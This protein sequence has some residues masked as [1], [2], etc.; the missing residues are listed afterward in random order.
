MRK[1]EQGAVTI[2]CII[3]L[4]S[5]ILLGGVM[6][7]GSRIL[8]ARQIVRTSMNSA[9][10]STL[11]YYSTDLVGDFGLYGVTE[12]DAKTQFK[13]YF[14]NNLTLSQNDGFNLYQFELGSNPVSVKVSAPLSQTEVFA[15][16]MSE[17]SKYRAGI[18]LTIGVVKKVGMLFGDKGPGN[19]VFGAVD[20]SEKA[21]NDLKKQSDRFGRAVNT[22]LSSALDTQVKKVKEETMEK[23][24]NGAS[25]E[26]INFGGDILETLESVKENF[27]EMN[28]ALSAY[29]T[30]SQ[31]ANDKINSAKMTGGEYYDEE[32][33]TWRTASPNGNDN[34]NVSGNENTP[35]KQAQEIIDNA[36][37]TVAQASQGV[38]NNL[39]QIQAES[40]QIAVHQQ[41]INELN[42]KLGNSDQNAE[43]SLENTQKEMA[44][45]LQDN[46]ITDLTQ[47]NTR[48]EKLENQRSCL[49][50]GMID[51]LDPEIT[52]DPVLLEEEI[53][54]QKKLI[55]Q[56]TTLQNTLNQ[57]QSVADDRKKLKKELAEEEKKLDDVYKK[58]ENLYD[59]MP[60]S[61]T[62]S[63][64]INYEITV[65]DA[66]QQQSESDLAKA[67]QAVK[68]KLLGVM[69]EMGKNPYSVE[70][71]AGAVDVE[72]TMPK[73]D[74]DLIGKLKDT[75]SGIIEICTKPETLLERAY[76]VEYALD[77]FTFLTSQSSRPSHHFHFGE[78]E[79]FLKGKD[80][81]GEN[82][83]NVVSDITL[84]RLV[85][86]F[87]D[88]LI[89]TQSPEPLS[90]ALIALGRALMDTAG[91]IYEL[92]INGECV[93][94][95]SFKNVKLTYSDHLRLALLLQ[96]VGSKTETQ[97]R[98]LTMIDRTMDVKKAN[99]TNELYTRI[100]A[101]SEV[102]INLIMVTL[103][104]FGKMMPGQDVIQDGKF[105]IR[106][107][108][109][110]GY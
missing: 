109:S 56:G 58:I 102:K 35:G 33:K 16:Q 78:V 9:A 15:D 99:P 93:L 51:G 10:R 23:L 81:Q 55:E 92:L 3:V 63:S 100:E 21:Y 36:S 88:D 47:L 48:L 67:I 29:N 76:T 104:M 103:P 20:D 28:G 69:E 89:H 64:D 71:N 73:G 96:T 40:Q 30:E 41:K 86:N 14:E 34:V 66:D 49:E 17:Y 94:C 85:I 107:T 101:T 38:Q 105:T 75:A 84:L 97:Q 68:N 50:L 80:T 45:F 108:V 43:S 61:S 12:E 72:V 57:K 39:N 6:I 95:P 77:K 26:N 4:F 13:R 24:K 31:K 98:M 110:M 22:T 74:W 91:D 18:N 60:S 32:T 19:Q 46:N 79:Y 59:T 42:A 37:G 53:N 106:E 62:I 8:L 27:D 54:N 11:S 70:G 44:K 2:F 65:S 83:F 52:Q 90:R 7:D 87:V 5:I 25:P 1:K 82:I